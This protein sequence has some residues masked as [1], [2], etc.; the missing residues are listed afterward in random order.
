MIAETKKARIFAGISPVSG[1]TG[2]TRYLEAKQLPSRDTPRWIASQ[3]A[4]PALDCAGQ[5]T[6]QACRD[7]ARKDERSHE[8][9]FND[10][11]SSHM[12]DLYR[13]AYWLSGNRAVAEELVQ[14][15]LI[16]AWRSMDRLRDTKAAKAWLLTIV[17]RENAR[18]HGRRQLPKSGMPTEDLVDVRSD[19]D[20]STEAFV[21]RRA[22]DQLPPDYREP[23]L[24]Q[25]VYGYSQKEIAEQLGI[26]NAGAGTRLF[27]AREKM[28][29]LL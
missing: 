1:E 27:R 26:S 28:R 13:F 2:E 11:V 12:D 8:Q 25:I 14:E 10:L 17:R 7:C 21:L 18:Y 29:A 9:R 16:R 3:W 24:M 5:A 19:Y 22:L 6:R 15:T 23:L 4:A 20:T